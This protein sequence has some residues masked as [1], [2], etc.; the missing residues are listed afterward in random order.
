M[1]PHRRTVSRLLA[2]AILT[3]LAVQPVLA[4]QVPVFRYALERWVSDNYEVIILHKGTLSAADKER[5]HGLMAMDAAAEHLANIRVEHI[6]LADEVKDDPE[7]GKLWD[8][9]S[10]NNQP[11]L[12]V[13]YPRVANVPEPLAWVAPFTD[14]SVKMLVD[15]PVRRQVAQRIL[16]GDS[17]V[18]VFIPSGDKTADAKAL[19]TLKDELAKN[20]NDL[21]LPEQ[22]ILESDEFFQPETKVKLRLGFSVVTLDRNDPAESF[23]LR[24]LLLGEPDLADEK[25]PIAFPIIGRGRALYAVVGKGINPFFIG[26]TSKFIV[27]PCSCQVKNQNPGF[28]LLMSVKWDEAI[29]GSAIPQVKVPQ[30]TGMASLEGAV[31]PLAVSTPSGKLTD[32]AETESGAS[33]ST[34]QIRSVLAEAPVVDVSGSSFGRN[35]A[36]MVMVG[37][38]LLVAVTMVVRRGSA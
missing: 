23:F 21:K 22:D 36:L 9:H 14:A 35:Y 17:A 3:L 20:Q 5:M 29:T 27:G 8:R 15:S 38:V 12:V 31:K 32:A 13:L 33:A 30:L 37:L 6:D 7:F 26:D 4:C 25:Q 19:K 34:S 16:A 18:W 1:S 28:D 2:V 24:S 10:K 11:L